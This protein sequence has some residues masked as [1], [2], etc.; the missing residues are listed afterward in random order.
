MFQAYSVTAH[1]TTPPLHRPTTPPG[2]RASAGPGKVAKYDKMVD[3]ACASDEDL[4]ANKG[5]QHYS[6]VGAYC[7]C[8]NT[9]PASSFTNAL[10][11]LVA[12]SPG[13][14]H[15][16]NDM[17]KEWV[18]CTTNSLWFPI[19]I[20]MVIL[21]SCCI[22]V[23]G[24]DRNICSEQYVAATPCCSNDE[25]DNYSDVYVNSWPFIF[26]GFVLLICAY[27]RGFHLAAYYIARSLCECSTQFPITKY[28]PHNSYTNG[29]TNFAFEQGK[30]SVDGG[31][32]KDF[33]CGKFFT[34]GYVEASGR[35][36]LIMC[37]A[38]CHRTLHRTLHS[39]NSP[40]P[41][42]FTPT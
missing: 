23:F 41:Y 14:Y 34:A 25:R 42:L 40:L 21:H 29:W 30:T 9:A 33:Q 39:P 13:A 15:K 6:A 27:V 10:D 35:Q 8:E 1:A 12:D 4:P 3:Q 20:I 28:I 2:T 38:S 22:C 24:R 16:C 7:V 19:L 31:Y 36:T 18:N 26:P 32:M 37:R 17:S 5:L 11:D